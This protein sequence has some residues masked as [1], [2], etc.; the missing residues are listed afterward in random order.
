MPKYPNK[1]VYCNARMAH[2]QHNHEGP[3]N[4]QD[5]EPIDVA[6]RDSVSFPAPVLNKYCL[7]ASHTQRNFR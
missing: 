5:I 6:G 4:Y 7:F 2:E 1:F 3:R